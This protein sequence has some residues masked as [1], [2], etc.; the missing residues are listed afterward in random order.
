M[1]ACIERVDAGD[2][3]DIYGYIYSNMNKRPSTYVV[4]LFATGHC[5]P[6]AVLADTFNF[7]FGVDYQ[8]TGQSLTVDAPE[9]IFPSNPPV[10]LPA[11]RSR[12]SVATDDIGLFG[13]WFFGGVT[14]NDGPRSEAAFLGRASSLSLRYQRQEIS[15]RSTLT[16]P[17]DP[18]ITVIDVDVSAENYAADLRYVWADSGWYGLGNFEY[19]DID[20]GFVG[21]G[22][23]AESYGVGIGKY[24]AERTSV[25][26]SY[27]RVGDFSDGTDRLLLN[28]RHIGDLGTS[29]QYG[30]TLGLSDIDLPGADLGVGATLSLYPNRSVAFGV[31]VSDSLDGFDDR[32][33]YALVGGWFPTDRFELSARFGWVSGEPRIGPPFITVNSDDDDY[34]IGFRYRF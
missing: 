27:Q 3:V 23:T 30:A 6:T 24:V 20:F 14:A 7:E 32:T 15:P 17:P 13:T 11:T 5:L 4:L 18:P 1:V 26:F 21:A 22:N 29:W 34:G 28:V 31:E 19:T 8:Y 9:T 12:S 2:S 33:R 25:D 10:T 16:P